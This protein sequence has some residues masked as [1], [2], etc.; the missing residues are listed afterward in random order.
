M[1]VC[2]KCKTTKLDGKWIPTH[3]VRKNVT[4]TLC[5]TCADEV[6]QVVQGTLLIDGLF[7][8]QHSRQSLQLIQTEERRARNQNV[9]SRVVQIQRNR[10]PVII[11]TTNSLLAI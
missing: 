8:Q 6:K 9:Y 3:N 4:Y 5:P 10:N 2:K 11:K 7:F 1:L